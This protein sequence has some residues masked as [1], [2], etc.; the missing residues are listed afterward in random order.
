[1]SSLGLVRRVGL[2]C[3]GCV[4][5]SCSAPLPL[6][7]PLL[8][9]LLLRLVRFFALSWGAVSVVLLRR[10]SCVVLLSA[11]FCAVWC[12]AISFEL[13]GVVACFFWVFVTEP[14]C[15]LSSFGGAF[16]CCCPCL[17]AWFCKR[18]T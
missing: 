18:S 1:M 3:V 13:A 4:G 8:S 6:L 11:S 16:C 17:A 7:L 10:L 12:S 5:V 9:D 15:P 2:R 14:G